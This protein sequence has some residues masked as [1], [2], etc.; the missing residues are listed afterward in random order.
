MSLL[1]TGPVLG[2]DNI[3]LVHDLAFA[4]EPRWFAR[5]MR[6]YGAVVLAAARRARLV[7]VVS[8][9]VAAELVDAGVD[10]G[11]IRLVRPS[12]DA[13]FVAASAEAVQCT[14]QRFG[15][16][17]PYV[18]VVGY[19]HP[20]KGAATA[21]AAHRL[22]L[23]R[24]PHDLVLV[25]AMSPTFAPI[26]LQELSSVRVLG[27]V[28]ED[29]LRSL[30]TGAA[31]LIFPSLYEGFGL[32]PLEAIACGTPA[33]VSDTAALRESTHSMAELLPLGDVGAWAAAIIRAIDGDLRVS[34]LPQWTWDDAA[35]QLLAAL[36]S[37]SS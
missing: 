14:T 20:R 17:R 8:N 5:H 10:A 33:L 15:L 37:F 4:V 19:A 21:I 36:E 32:P 16:N 11:R 26:R 3:V 23:R 6:A 9:A 31:A 28:A 22:A 25:G 29:Q 1:N 13:D 30:L 7:L 18:L 2:R 24:R 27:Y 12:V 34:A 35:G